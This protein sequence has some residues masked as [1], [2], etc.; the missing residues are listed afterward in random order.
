MGQLSRVLYDSGFMPT[1]RE[2][3]FDD[4]G[5]LWSNGHEVVCDETGAVLDRKEKTL[6]SRTDN[7]IYRYQNSGRVKLPGGYI[8]AYEWGDDG[9][10]FTY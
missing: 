10:G 7:S 3:P 5:E 8:S 2:S 4:D 1:G 9:R 6:V